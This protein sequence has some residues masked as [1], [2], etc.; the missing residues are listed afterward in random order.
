MADI[1]KETKD[2]FKGIIE[3]DPVTGEPSGTLREPSAMNLVAD[4]LPTE[5][6]ELRLNGLL[7]A[8]SLASSFGITSMIDAGKTKYPYLHCLK[9]S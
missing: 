2:P 4:V 6:P 7:Y 9:A 8:Q 5:T 1:N 3:R